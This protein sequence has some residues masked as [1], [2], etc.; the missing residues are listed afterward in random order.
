MAGRV[1]HWKHGWIPLTHAAAL[2]KAHGSESGAHKYLAS[3]SQ[4]DLPRSDHITV[5]FAPNG[6]FAVHDRKTGQSVGLSQPEAD[7]LRSNGQKITGVNNGLQTAASRKEPAFLQGVARFDGEH[8]SAYRYANVDYDPSKVETTINCV[9]VAQA[10]ELRRRGYAVSAQHGPAHVLNETLADMWRDTET[11]KPIQ[12]HTAHSRADLES[13]TAGDPPGARY[14]VSAVW[15][16]QPPGMSG[17]HMF[18]AEKRADGSVSYFD[19]QVRQS[20]ASPHLDAADFSIFGVEIY[21]VDNATPA[22]NPAWDRII[23][24]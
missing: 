1:Y 17:S 21:R 7:R 22:D 15:K 13:V 11:G 19:A 4:S 18:N 23:N 3:V 16:G 12:I 2:S 10:Y 5:G 20:D 14:H 24:K 6:R 9:K 8:T